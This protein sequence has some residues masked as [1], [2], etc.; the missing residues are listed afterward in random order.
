MEVHYVGEHL[1]A[2]RLGQFSIYVSLTFSLAAAIAFFRS[3]YGQAE[4]SR[5]MNAARA[6][7]IVHAAAVLAVGSLLFVII[8]N[9]WFEYYY[10]WSHSSRELPKEYLLSCF[11]EGQEG[12]FLLWM[13]WNAVLGLVLLWRRPPAVAGV[14]SVMALVQF[15]LSSMLLGVYVFGYKIGSTPFA[16]LRHEMQDAPIFQR[17]DYLSFI[18]DG[19]GLNPLLQNYWMVIHP[20][21]LF[22]GFAATLIPFAYASHGLMSRNFGDWARPVLPWALF[23]AATLGA[24]IMMGGAWAYESLT[25]GGYWAWDPVENASLVP[26]LLLIAAIHTNVVYLHSG[27]SLRATFLF[28]LL[29]FIFVLY[30]TF[31]TR[32]GILGDTSVH[33]FTDLG[34]SGQLLLYMASISIPALLLLAVY[35]RRIPTIAKE[36]AALSREFWIFVGTLLLFLSSVQITFSTSIPVWN[37][38][39]GTN[40]APPAD[41]MEHYNKWQLPI[42]IAVLLFSSA[43]LFLRYRSSDARPFWRRM[44]LFAGIAAVLTALLEWYFRFANAAAI[45]LLFAALFGCCACGF[46]IVKNLRGRFKISGGAVAHFGFSLLLLGV[47]ISSAKKEV[48]SINNGPMSLGSSFTEEQNRTNILLLKNMPVTLRN[49][50]VTYLGDSAAPPNYYYKVLWEHFDTSTGSLREQF[51]L[52]PN[53]QINPRMGLIANPDTRHYWHKDVYTHVT[54]VPDKTKPR[55]RGEPRFRDYTV[56]VGDSIALSS[57]TLIIESLGPALPREG[58]DWKPDDLAVEARIDIRMHD[59]RW[60][61]AKPVYLIRGLQAYFLDEDLAEIGL[62]LR[63]ARILPKEQK[64]QIA[65]EEREPEHDFIVLTAI[66]FPYI[67]LVWLGTI[68]TLLGFVLAMLQRRRQSANAVP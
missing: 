54:S 2:G 47:L 57:G 37:K 14:M 8:Q 38:V 32:S 5:W 16:L 42:A 53:A 50:V 67:N 18:E 65:V 9:H 35:W 10:A 3:Q 7:F 26:W 56:A 23:A 55:T 6:A 28:Y 15:F 40:W 20:P 12:S 11:W 46:L 33:A 58:Q 31:L 66:V 45:L 52:W 39:F 19:N 27:R 29:T 21:V 62:T 30:S 64:I 34:M 61:S 48:I 63:L 68:F 60:F 22:L 4:T 59:G 44:V 25:F 41:P 17:A 13:F 24:G 1:W 49:Y 51:I 43:A 36:E